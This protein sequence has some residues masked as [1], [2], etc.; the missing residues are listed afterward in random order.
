MSKASYWQRGETLDF[1]NDTD[2]MIEENTIIKIV[3]R[4]GVVGAPIAP[5]EIGSLHVSGV[6]EMPKKQGEELLIGEL[7]Y[8]DGNEITKTET[9]NTLAGYAAAPAGADDKNAIIKLMG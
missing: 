1:K 6:F 9:S 2:Q 5:G 7:A 3:T 8:F 4:V